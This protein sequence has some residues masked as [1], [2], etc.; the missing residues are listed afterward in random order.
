MLAATNI[1]D[2]ISGRTLNSNAKGAALS[3]FE[4]SKQR[5]FNQL[6]IG[7]KLPTLIDAIEQD[8]AAERHVLVQ[9]VTTTE[10]M[11]ER[12]LA[13]LSPDERETLEIELSPREILIQY[14]ETAFP[15]RQM[16]V[17]KGTDGEPRS[18][19]M[20]DEDGNAVHSQEAVRARDD[21]IEQL[22]ALPA[23]PG[24]LDGLIRHFGTDVLAE[25][26]GRKRRV[27]TDASGVQRIERRSARGNV[28][29][30]KAFM[31]AHKSILAFSDVGGTASMTIPTVG[32]R[33]APRAE[34]RG[35]S[36]H[37]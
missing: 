21:L 14:L 11:L 33:P 25:V 18:E 37:P 13:R 28:A 32:G 22:C 35:I 16:R 19:L 1:V 7:M 2:R 29:E 34:R 5:F 27:V 15:T 23:I 17:F 12:Q 36:R 20:V 4:S 24:A 8:L 6:L 26:T 10:A 9:L 3:R 30:L 31:A